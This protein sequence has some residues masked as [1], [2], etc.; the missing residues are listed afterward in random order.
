MRVGIPDGFVV[1]EVA[2]G[3]IS[4]GCIVVQRVGRVLAVSELDRG[5]LRIGFEVLIG[6]QF[7]LGGELNTAQTA[8]CDIIHAERKRILHIIRK[9]LA[10]VG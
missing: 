4:L 3:V 2:V 1:S 10:V 6:N 5:E 7:V 9:V 8:C